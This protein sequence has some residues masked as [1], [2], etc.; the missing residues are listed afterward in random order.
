ML[1][2][3]SQ[4]P[5]IKCSGS[6]HVYPL[7]RGDVS[8]TQCLLPFNNSGEYLAMLYFVFLRTEIR[9]KCQSSSVST[10]HRILLLRSEFRLFRSAY[11]CATSTRSP[12]HFPYRFIDKQTRFYTPNNTNTAL[13]FHHQRWFYPTTAFD[14]IVF[15]QN[16]ISCASL[17]VGIFMLSHSTKG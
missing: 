9:S 15:S 3:K 5:G 7:R 4:F 16:N 8:T 17:F 6:I 14:W 1:L 13:S 2:D 11:K 12:F 10:K